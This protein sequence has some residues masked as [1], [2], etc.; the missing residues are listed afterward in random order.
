MFIK[1]RLKEKKADVKYLRHVTCFDYGLESWLETLVKNW[2]NIET[3]YMFPGEDKRML[4]ECF[5]GEESA[6]GNQS[7]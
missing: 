5:W 7:C 3:N 2:R 6:D 4:K 1:L